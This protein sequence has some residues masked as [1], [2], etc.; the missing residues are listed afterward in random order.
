MVSKRTQDIVTDAKKYLIDVHSPIGEEPW[1]VIESGHGVWLK[2]TEGRE[3]IDT[4]SGGGVAHLGHGRKE[5]IDAIVEQLNKIER[6]NN[7]SGEVGPIQ[8]ECAKK[9]AQIT[10]EGLDHVHF[11]TGG[12]EANDMAFKM[13]YQYWHLQNKKKEKIISLYGGYHGLGTA[14]W[15]SSRPTFASETW[16]P[17]APG[18]LHIPSYHCY[19]CMF[20]LEYPEC[21]VRCA[22]YLAQ[23]IEYERPET[24]AAFIAEPVLGG[25]GHIP[26]PPEYWP[27]V[28]Q[29]CD[30]YG[31]LLIADE[32]QS[33]FGRTG[34][35]FA[36]ENW[37]VKPDIMTMA[38][39]MAGGYVPFGGVS[40][41]E[42]IF[43]ALKG[44]QLTQSYTFNGHSVG[45]A[46]ALA[47]MNIYTKEKVPENA[48]KVGKHIFERF[49]AEFR[50]LP[51]VDNI[52]HLGLSLGMDIVADRKTKAPLPKA[53]RERLVHQ[54]WENGIAVRP[55]GGYGGTRERIYPPCIMTIEEADIMV[56]RLLELISSIKV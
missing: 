50:S 25:Y 2:D 52:T 18:F 21:D 56:D 39:S 6:V 44:F 29:I 13:A 15:S 38:K 45:C 26:P 35:M 53:L 37:G 33:G 41:N 4:G 3:G 20:S 27:I 5:I 34:K 23:V 48:A 9:L 10:P 22:R 36:L 8:T 11:L 54:A 16:G 47:A 42:K 31:V 7:W 46:A 55:I 28:R 32:V 12:A 49:D 24:V 51:C 43:Q 30:D 17:P 14:T 19:R 40:I 1:L